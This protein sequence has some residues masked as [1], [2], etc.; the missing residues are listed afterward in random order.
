MVQESYKC[1]FPLF[2]KIEI[3]GE[4]CH[5][6]YAFLRNNSKELRKNDQAGVIPWNFAKFFVKNG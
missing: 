2:A 4:N 1:H 5:P 6:V 3:N